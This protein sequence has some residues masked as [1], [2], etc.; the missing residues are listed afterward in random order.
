MVRCNLS[1]LLAERNLKITQ[2]AKD[3][4]ISRTTLTYLANNYSKGIQYD[5]LNTLCNYLNVTPDEL[6]SYVPIDIYISYVHRNNEDLE[7]ELEITTNGS[8]FTCGLCGSAYLYFPDRDDPYFIGNKDLN[9][10]D[11]VE[12]N[13]SLWQPIEDDP[14]LENENSIIVHALNR[15]PISFLKDIE[16]IIIDDIIQDINYEYDLDGSEPITTYFS[17][18]DDVLGI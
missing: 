6:I 14:E 16:N 7:I 8:T 1:I 2:V 17:W 9:K 15:L 11:S 5:T 10:P 12:I 18:D 4:G 3:T 13:I